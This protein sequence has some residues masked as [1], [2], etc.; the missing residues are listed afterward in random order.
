M[1]MF[2]QSTEERTAKF[3]EEDIRGRQMIGSIR[4]TGQ[5]GAHDTRRTGH[6]AGEGSNSHIG[7][8][9]VYGLFT[10]HHGSK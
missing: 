2:W 1:A 9:P 6:M 7:L 10:Q 4:S 3:L 8:L 5:H